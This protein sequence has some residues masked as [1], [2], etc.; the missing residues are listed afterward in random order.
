M[1]YSHNIRKNHIL[2]LILLL[3][4]TVI[5]SVAYIQT[6]SGARAFLVL[7]AVDANQDGALTIEEVIPMI[8]GIQKNIGNDS[9]LYD[10][11]FDGI[12]TEKDLLAVMDEA[13]KHCPEKMRAVEIMDT[14]SDL[15]ITQSERDI[16]I[17]DALQ[18]IEEKN[19]KYD[20]NKN[21]MITMQD[22]L[23][24]RNTFTSLRDM[25]N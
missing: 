11:D 16:F 15:V 9:S 18:A 21:G 1:K 6:I 13:M 22:I 8:H 3:I 4:L 7:S 14:D 24:G 10:I 23:I 19:V 20:L 2:A 17:I 25:A 5:F 12:V